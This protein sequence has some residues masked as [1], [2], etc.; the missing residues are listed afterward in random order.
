MTTS[1]DLKGRAGRNRP[2]ATSQEQTDLAKR[3]S[4]QLRRLLN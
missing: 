3:S 4:K 1:R 2:T